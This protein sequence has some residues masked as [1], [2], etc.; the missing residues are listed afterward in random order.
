MDCRSQIEH[1]SQKK[2]K[3]KK[4]KHGF[5]KRAHSGPGHAHG[6]GGTSTA[7]ADHLAAAARQAGLPDPQGDCDRRNRRVIIQ[8]TSCLDIASL[9]IRHRVVELGAACSFHT[10]P[11]ATRER[12]SSGSTT[13]AGLSPLTAKSGERQGRRAP[14]CANRGT[15]PES[16][17]GG[18]PRLAPGASSV[19]PPEASASRP[20]CTHGRGR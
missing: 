2:L 15:S 5:R 12:R 14:T 16:L 8:N 13:G 11:V 4:L 17:S 6:D 20:G 9:F 18:C 10:K 7:S 1:G 3:P 19:D